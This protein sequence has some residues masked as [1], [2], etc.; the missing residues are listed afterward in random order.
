MDHGRLGVQT[1]SE[2][3]ATLEKTVRE[4]SA[5]EKELDRLYA[6]GAAASRAVEDQQG[7]SISS[8]LD[9]LNRRVQSAEAERDEAVRERDSA[10]NQITRVE[11]LYANTMPVY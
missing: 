4:K 11:L 8:T 6:E 2:K 7:Q 1:I 3:Q 5:V 9:Q 10:Q